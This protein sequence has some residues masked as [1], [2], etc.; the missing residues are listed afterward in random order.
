MCPPLLLQANLLASVQ[1]R[2]ADLQARLQRKA[3]DK[4]DTP[5]LAMLKMAQLKAQQ[6]QQ[7]QQQ[8]VRQP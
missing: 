2:L 6:P 1:S 5:V 3:S 7:P 8:Q 4:G